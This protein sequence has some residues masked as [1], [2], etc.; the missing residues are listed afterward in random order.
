M[1]GVCQRAKRRNLLLIGRCRIE[2]LDS[3]VMY[4]DRTL[5]N[6]RRQIYTLSPSTGFGGKITLFASDQRKPRARVFGIKVRPLWRIMLHRLG[7]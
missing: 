2:T 4:G 5:F 7:T 3:S 6:E 1:L